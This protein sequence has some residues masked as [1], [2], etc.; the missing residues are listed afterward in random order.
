MVGPFLFVDV[1]VSVNMT[2]Y[3]FLVLIKLNKHNCL[4]QLTF[5]SNI[6][7]YLQQ[8]QR[9]LTT[10]RKPFENIERKG[11][12]ADNQHLLNFPLFSILY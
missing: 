9:V 3:L 8:N 12:S 5:V 10:L 6:L 4:V 7:N 11:E 1:S 2:V